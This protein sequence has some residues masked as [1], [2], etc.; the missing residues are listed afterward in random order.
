MRFANLVEE[1]LSVTKQFI[2][3]CAPLIIDLSLAARAVITI[4]SKV[5]VEDSFTGALR[6]DL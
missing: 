4:G 6:V 1:Y 5:C 3:T 2:T